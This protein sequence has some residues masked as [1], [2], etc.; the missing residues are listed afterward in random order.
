MNVLVAYASKHGSTAEI[1]GVIGNDFR[2]AGFDVDIQQADNVTT[3]APYD[4][5]IIGSAIYV[6]QWQRGALQFIDHF[7]EQLKSRHVWL[8]SSGPIGVDPKPAEEPPVTEA[9]IDRTGAVE[10]QSFTGKLDRSNLGFGDRLIASVVRAPEGDFRDW[11]AIRAWAMHIVR[12]L[13]DK[14]MKS[15]ASMSTM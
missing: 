9:L 3:L 1:A 7:E 8:F 15:T 5:V 10:H 12:Q 2:E 11:D 4:T 14:A 6:G 13:Q